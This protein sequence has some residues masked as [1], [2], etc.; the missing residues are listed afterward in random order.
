MA[1]AA[2]QVSHVI[3]LAVAPVFLLTSIGT[4]LS[5]LSSRLAR[6]IDR[7]RVLAERLESQS[8]APHHVAIRSE[9]AVLIRRRHYINIAITAGVA[10]A[11]FVCVLMT[12]AFVAAL[13][14]AQFPTVLV[15]LF[16]TS[17]ISI[18]VALLFFLREVLLS[19]LSYRIDVR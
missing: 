3:Q 8:E 17:M 7:A 16:I 18:V 5:V 11:L 4:I 14:N 13:F 15:A 12:A 9:L 10:A 19:A 1:S 6:I 2:E